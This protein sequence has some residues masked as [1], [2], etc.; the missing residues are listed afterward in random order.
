MLAYPML[1]LRRM[2]NP[3]L[4]PASRRLHSETTQLHIADA[5]A[6]AHALRLQPAEGR[7]VVLVVADEPMQ[8][9]ISETVQASGRE[10]AAA[11]TPFDAMQILQRRGDEIGVAIIA[12]QPGWGLKFRAV[13]ATEHPAIRRITLVG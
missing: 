13:L 4:H 1:T 12:S 11:G 3:Q 9:R 6:W 5:P 2:G 8:Q 7:S 10:V